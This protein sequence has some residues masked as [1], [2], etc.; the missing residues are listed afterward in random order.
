MEVDVEILDVNE[1]DARK[2]LLSIDP[3]AALAEMQLHER[4]MEMAPTDSAE[5]EAAWKTAA[6]AA[7]KRRL[8]IDAAP[9][10]AE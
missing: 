5:L 1:E 4:L 3:F 2:L 9:I 6:R 8:D 10:S 7:V